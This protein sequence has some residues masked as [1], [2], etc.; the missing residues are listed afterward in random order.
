MPVSRTRMTATP[1]TPPCEA[2]EREGSRSIVSQMRPPLSVNLQALLK[3]LPITCASLI[4][5][6]CRYTGCGGSVTLR[7][8]F[9]HSM[10]GR[11]AS[12]A[13]YTIDASSTR[14]L[15]SSILPRLMRLTSSKSS[16]SRTI[17]PI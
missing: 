3:R 15:R 16:T 2:G 9:A 12:T 1:P 17:C 8:C 14:S 6:P 11:Q 7:S 10:A 5:S 4:G 13:W